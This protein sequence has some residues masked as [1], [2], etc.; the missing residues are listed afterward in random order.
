M[1]K[2]KVIEKPC[3]HFIV[4]EDSAVWLALYEGAVFGKERGCAELWHCTFALADDIINVHF[5]K[6]LHDICAR[7]VVHFFGH[8]DFGCFIERVWV[9]SR[10]FVV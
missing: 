8:L 2:G 4:V 3:A 9:Q 7:C 10:S 6:N 1:L 5:L